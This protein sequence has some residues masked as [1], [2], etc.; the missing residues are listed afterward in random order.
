[1]SNIVFFY[2]L[3]IFC[4]YLPKLAN[5]IFFIY[6][7]LVKNQIDRIKYTVTKKNFIAANKR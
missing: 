5:A 7:R 1:M 3:K 6:P 2:F 4:E